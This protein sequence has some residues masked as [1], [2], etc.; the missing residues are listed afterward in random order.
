[1][2]HKL[3]LFVAWKVVKVTIQCGGAYSQSRRSVLP[4]RK[5]QRRTTSPS[6]AT[7]AQTFTK[8]R[9]AGSRVTSKT[10][11]AGEGNVLDPSL[12]KGAIGSG[13]GKRAARWAVMLRVRRIHL[14]P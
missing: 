10:A 5:R 14:L 2:Y 12:R 8:R 7:G 9:K 4:S 1:M 3:H 13:F 11:F 6:L